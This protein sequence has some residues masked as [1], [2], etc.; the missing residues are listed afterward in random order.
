MNHCPFCEA[1]I[2]EALIRDMARDLGMVE[3]SYECGHELDGGNSCSREVSGP[4]EKCW[5]HRGT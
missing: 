1:P 5:Q 4:D 2:S 3:A